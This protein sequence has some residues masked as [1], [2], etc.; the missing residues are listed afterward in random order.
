MRNGGLDSV[1]NDVGKLKGSP[2]TIRKR[3]NK[4]GDPKVTPPPV[5][6]GSYGGDP[7]GT[8]GTEMRERNGIDELV[9]IAGPLLYAAGQVVANLFGKR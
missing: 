8:W 7:F 2:D 9:V 3:L 4:E 1:K 6:G 5:V